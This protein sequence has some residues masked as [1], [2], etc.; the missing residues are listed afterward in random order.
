MA[1]VK[2]S[3]LP[4]VSSVAGSDIVPVVASS[5]TSQLSITNLA[6]SLPQV[7][8]SISASFAT[9]AS[10]VAAALTTASV[11][12]NVITFTKGDESQF[13]VTVDTG[14][15]TAI[16]PY[17][18]SAAITGSLTVTGSTSISGSHRVSGNADVTGSITISSV[19][20]MGGVTSTRILPTSNTTNFSILPGGSSTEIAVFPYIRPGGLGGSGGSGLYTYYYQDLN[21]G[22]TKVTGQLVAPAIK[23]TRNQITTDNDSTPYYTVITDNVTVT[24]NQVTS[25]GNE[26]WRANGRAH[27]LTVATGSFLAREGV[28]LGTNISNSH[29]VTGSVNITGS[30]LVNGS[31]VGSAFPFTG[32]ARIT[33][34][35]IVSSSL[36]V[37]K[38]LIDVNNGNEEYVGK[39]S[40]SIW[41]TVQGLHSLAITNG[42]SVSGDFAFG[43]GYNNYA[44]NYY[45]HAQ[46]QSTYAGG[47]GSHAEGYATS[48]FGEGS[49]AEGS[50]SMAYGDYSHAEGWGTITS[51]SC[52]LVI[53]QYNISSSAQSAFIIGNGTAD[54]SRSNLLFASGSRVQITGSL[55]IT[56][57]ATISDVL[58]LPFQSP[59]PS[60]KPTGSVAISGSG[61]TFVGMF[62]YNGTSWTNV[63]A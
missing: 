37:D 4:S 51:G 3:G 10:F 33:G 50:G 7:N 20:R 39:G 17:T 27:T 61:G 48:T 21:I 2:I 54:N 14:S 16:F 55:T 47:I 46:G 18:G 11:A 28:S 44:T 36:K 60:G 6:N 56:G 40:V 38:L 41:G 23:I 45:S 58:V 8:S 12:S 19:A 43:Q 22:Y 32:N 35:L 31:S 57:S 25:Y 24:D 9:T 30:L 26:M 49:H 15:A 42:G 52:Q 1:N 63:K 13:S 62:V 34:S 29:I 53:G 59:L 5:T